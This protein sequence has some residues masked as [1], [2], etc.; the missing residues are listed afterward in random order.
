MKAHSINKKSSAVYEIRYHVILV[1]KYRKKILV[2]DVI[3]FLNDLFHKIAKKRQ[4]SI[5][6][7]AI[8]PDQTGWFSCNRSIKEPTQKGNVHSVP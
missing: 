2:G 1:T 5:Q 3:P 7:L 8:Q 4:L 6:S